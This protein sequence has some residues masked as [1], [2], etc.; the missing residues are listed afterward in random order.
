MGFSAYVDGRRTEVLY[1]D[2]WV[3]GKAVEKGGR[4]CEFR[5]E[6]IRK[7][8]KKLNRPIKVLDIGANM[9]YFSFRLA[10]EF[11]GLFVM[12]EGSE[13]VSRALLK[14]CKLNRNK[15]SILLKRSLTLECLKYLAKNETFD[16]VLALSI[17]HHF[18]EPY[19]E[20]FEVLRTLG[21]YLIFE[22]PI[23]E[24]NT[25]NQ[26]RIVSEPIEFKK[27]SHKPIVK[28]PCASKY[29]NHLYR[30]TYLLPCQEEAKS[31]MMAINLETYLNFNGIFPSHDEFM[32]FKNSQDVD[33]KN[34]ILTGTELLPKI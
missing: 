18:E 3:C 15:K 13:T 5:Y 23:L 25:L 33:P 21:S 4:E 28:I 12:V 30:T 22:P 8:V 29:S 32:L 10:E 2:A 9:G 1:Q 6:A 7:V 14:L 26:K 34:F 31:N 11:D 20:V 27:Y 19:N 16:F 17:I 24:E